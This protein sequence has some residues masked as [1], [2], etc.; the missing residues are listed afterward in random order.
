MCRFHFVQSH[1]DCIVNRS[2]PAGTNAL[3]RAL[4][5]CL[6]ARET[7]PHVDVGVERQQEHLVLLRQG[8]RY[9]ARGLQGLLQFVTHAAA[10]I[11]HDA[12]AYRY[13]AIVGEERN[14]LLDAIFEHLKVFLL[15]SV[16]VGSAFVQHGGGDVDQIYIGRKFEIGILGG[17]LR[18]R[19]QYRRSLPGRRLSDEQTG[20]KSKCSNWCE[21][22]KLYY[23]HN[24]YTPGFS[25]WN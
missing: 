8:Q 19:R 22:M 4:D 9:F 10:D 13:L 3:E 14:L 7:L 21:P 25:G 15:Q 12:N 6:V 18:L 1:F 11:D 5:E 24:V 17:R 16:N 23:S 20:A 2:I